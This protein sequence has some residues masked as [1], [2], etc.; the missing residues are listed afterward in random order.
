MLRSIGRYYELQ[1]NRLPEAF[2]PLHNAFYA[3]P[4]RRADEQGAGAGPQFARKGGCHALQQEMRVAG[5]G[6]DAAGGASS[7]SS[8]ADGT[9]AAAAAGSPP[10]WPPMVPLEPAASTS[11]SGG[12]AVMWRASMAELAHAL[13]LWV[14]PW[15]APPAPEASEAE[16]PTT[17]TAGAGP[18]ASPGEGTG[19]GASG[20]AGSG[21]H[22]L[23]GGVSRARARILLQGDAGSGKSIAVAA[24][25]ERARALGW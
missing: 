5:C 15:P 8:S 14:G 21:L 18:E 17:T 24:M 6:A 16:H 1:A 7:S 11:T 23:R 22:R 10:R 25:V 12:P 20:G 2:Q 9:G 13:S 3:P 19:S 4:K